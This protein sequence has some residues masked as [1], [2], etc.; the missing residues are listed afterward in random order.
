MKIS[1][2]LTIKRARPKA[3]LIAGLLLT[4]CMMVAILFSSILFPDGG[5]S[6]D[7]AARLQPPFLNF[8]HPLGTDPLGRDVLA[9]IVV[10]G[11]ISIAVG[12]VSVTG[13]VI[14][15]TLMGLF[16]G[17]YRGIW[18]ILVMRFVDIQ[19]A[20]PFILIAITFTA[21]L[22]TDIWKLILFMVITQWVQYAR[23]TRSL[24]LVLRDREYIHAARGIG[25]SNLT[26]IAHHIL[27]NA[28][29]PI[30]A[31][32]T[33]NVANNILL[34]SSLTFLGLGVDPL[35]PSW[36]G[37][38]ADGRIYLQTAWWICI[39]P[40]LAIMITV[41]GLNFLGDWLREFLDPTG[42]VS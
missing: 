25:V 1:P 4:G 39:F 21:I 12:V 40:G 17:Y 13:G 2:L 16:A 3:E 33:L 32:T 15:G 27:P 37:M 34:E 24:V 8:A 26:I 23:V 14:I 20:L 31:L 5:T 35:I 18:D 11:K 36:G 42:K 10:G 38:L 6:M 19:L 41:L 9:R 7:L 22:G 29:G 30:L 28:M